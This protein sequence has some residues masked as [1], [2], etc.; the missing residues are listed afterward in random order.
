[1]SGVDRSVPDRRHP[2]EDGSDLFHATRVLAAA[3][4]P[5]LAIAAVILFSF[6]ADTRRLFA[7]EIRPPMTAMMLGAT[8][9][10][11]VWFFARASR[12]G[13]WREV[14]VGF[15][16]VGT[17][18][19]VLGIA[20]VLHWDRFIHDSLAFVLWTLLYL[21]TPFLV[22]GTWLRQ[23]SRDRDPHEAEITL[24]KAVRFGF[25]ALGVG[26]LVVAVAL[27]LAPTNVGAA[28][29]WP[30]TPLTG[31]VMSA[32]FALPG[33][34]GVGLAIDPRWSVARVVVEA[35][36]I[37]IVLILLGAW[38]DQASIRF[39]APSGWLFVGGLVAILLAN[40]TMYLAFERRGI[41]LAAAAPGVDRSP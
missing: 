2:P 23:R 33:L 4:I 29:P 17:F 27:F 19:S 38:R 15:P 5:F 30:L 25:G 32:M 7:W 41:S 1:M 39:D 13:R 14:N 34:V 20:T 36:V 16:A 12:A 6:P 40:L 10:G 3:I 18:A 21:T 24:P 22:F 37:S 28:W 35:E 9:T 8:Y 26:M 31:R 11:G